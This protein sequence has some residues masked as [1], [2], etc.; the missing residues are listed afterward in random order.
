[1][2]VL[3]GIEELDQYICMAYNAILEDQ[4]IHPTK[5]WD[6]ASDLIKIVDNNHSAKVFATYNHI[7][8]ILQ[9]TK[10]KKGDV[11]EIIQDITSW[12]A[13][14]SQAQLG[15][16]YTEL[17]QSMKN[18]I[19]T[20]TDDNII[21]P[22]IR[23]KSSILT[24]LESY[25]D[26]TIGNM[27]YLRWTR[28]DRILDEILDYLLSYYHRLIIAISEK[29]CFDSDDKD[30][31]AIKDLMERFIILHKGADL[32]IK[33]LNA[34]DTQSDLS[35]FIVD[36]FLQRKLN[37]NIKR[38]DSVME[39]ERNVKERALQIYENILKD[40]NIPLSKRVHIERNLANCIL[41]ESEDYQIRNYGIDIICNT[42]PLDIAFDKIK[43]I[44]EN[45]ILIEASTNEIT[46]HCPTCR[47][48]VMDRTVQERA[49]HIY[50]N[51]LKDDGTHNQ[52]KGSIERQIEMLILDDHEDV[53]TRKLAL[54]IVCCTRGKEDAFC[55][56]KGFLVKI[57]ENQ[58]R[59]WATTRQCPNCG[60]KI[61]DDE[62]MYCVRCRCKLK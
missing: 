17:L 52:L 27:E 18:S 39:A 47:Q 37:Y 2:N 53:E 44:L 43:G 15:Q 5:E 62:Q 36:R 33:A 60:Q 8:D 59:I 9:Q 1:M 13:T 61:T 34:I 3:N 21:E 55:K 26:R 48:T 24:I 11:L 57:I 4:K 20:L 12:G 56:T 38:D 10:T 50:E 40:E 32:R 29:S 14:V 6:H 31:F 41:N 22:M 46:Q 16:L 49:L 45:V 42:R 19:H 25:A 58:G 7:W 30:T 23:D 35:I 54:N 51:V 28:N